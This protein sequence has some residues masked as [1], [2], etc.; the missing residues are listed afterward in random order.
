MGLLFHQLGRTGGRTDRLPWPAALSD[1]EGKLGAK[2][3]NVWSL[4][5]LR[6]RQSIRAIHDPWGRQLRLLD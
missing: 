5:L 4:L 1:L 2:M 3:T 6:R